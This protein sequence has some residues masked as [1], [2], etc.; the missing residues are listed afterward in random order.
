MTADL[1]HEAGLAETCLT[2]DGEDAPLAVEE[3][4]DAA[5]DCGDLGV[6]ADEGGAMP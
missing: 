3:A 2:D 1:R 4:V 5:L 6:A